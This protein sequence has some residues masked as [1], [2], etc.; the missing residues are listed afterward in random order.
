MIERHRTEKRRR[1]WR[2]FWWNFVRDQRASMLVL[3]GLTAPV[4]F[5][6]ALG[7]TDFAEVV[8][9]K[10]ALQGDVDEAALNGARELGTDRSSATTERARVFA[11]KLAA[12]SQRQ[13]TVLTSARA[14]PLDGSMTVVQTASRPSYFG[15][16]L[17][18]GGWHVTVTSTA[19]ANSKLPLCV[20]GLQAG[21]TLPIALQLTS[22]MTANG[23]LVQSDG[24]LQVSSGAALVAGAVRAVGSAT[25]SILP[26]PVADA[27]AVADPFSSLNI[28]IPTTCNDNGAKLTNGT[29]SLNPGVHCG[30]VTVTGPS[31]LILNPGEHYFVKGS[32]TLTG[33]A[34]I[35]G[36]D[37]V[38][39]FSNNT[40][41]S[42]SGQSSLS[43][44]GRQSGPYAG[45]VLVTDRA[46]TGTLAISAT[47]A[48]KV[49]GTVYLPAATLSISG[50]NPVADLSPWTIIVANDLQLG[51]SASLVINTNYSGSTVP[52]PSGVGSSGEPHLTK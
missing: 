33:S 29:Q 25:G 44:D 21:S 31:N 4:L 18:P 32:V 9:T 47:N 19:I 45:F 1:F 28:A 40:G 49:H 24:N 38:A 39:I 50:A 11:A 36:T 13:W 22:V 10:H 20:L 48:R 17:P 12:E 2:D 41:I 3:F 7:V 51:G 6:L 26:A 52:V 42:F 16:L 43:L 15:N 46:Y 23:C 8:M 30:N 35:T 34:Q 37:V 5:L 14:N 27:P